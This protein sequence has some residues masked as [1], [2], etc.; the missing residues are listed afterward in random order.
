MLV[1][2]ACKSEADALGKEKATALL[3]LLIG[4]LHYFKGV[5]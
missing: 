4:N 3:V 1:A 2:N 5:S